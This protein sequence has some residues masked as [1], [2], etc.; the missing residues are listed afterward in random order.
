[1]ALTDLGGVMD[2]LA[3]AVTEATTPFTQRAQAWPAESVQPPQVVVG[4]PESI[5]FD[6]TFGK[7]ATRGADKATIPLYFVLGAVTART[8]RDALSALLADATGIKALIEDYDSDGAWQTV[9]VTDCR[10]EAIKIGAVEYLAGRFDC[11]VIA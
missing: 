3:A 7:A 5:D 6:V 8:T 4:Y 1:M 10:P 11:E 9:R 2:A